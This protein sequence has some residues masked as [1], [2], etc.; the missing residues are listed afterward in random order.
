MIQYHRGSFF[1]KKFFNLDE[2]NTIRY[3]Y[4]LC[5]LFDKFFGLFP[6]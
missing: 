3:A 4:I 2:P 5:Y 6:K 1:W